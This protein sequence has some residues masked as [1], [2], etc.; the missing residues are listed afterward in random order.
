[1]PDWSPD[2]RKIVFTRYWGETRAPQSFQLLTMNA[3]G[4]AMRAVTS[5]GLDEGA[6]YLPDGRIL[7]YRGSSHVWVVANPGG[8]HSRSTA[9]HQRW[10]SLCV[11]PNGNRIALRRGLKVPP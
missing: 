1:M 9:I 7:Y 3:D 8:T 5:R 11:L 10:A 4:S 2:G 6:S